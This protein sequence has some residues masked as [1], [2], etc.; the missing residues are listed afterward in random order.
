MKLVTSLFGFLA[1]VNPLFKTA[2]VVL[3]SSREANF[4][5]CRD[6]GL[7]RLALGKEML[8]DPFSR[9]AESAETMGWRETMQHLADL[10]Q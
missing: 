1:C 5:L 2:E 4:L 10:A 3:V 6:S 9:P 7:T 8:L